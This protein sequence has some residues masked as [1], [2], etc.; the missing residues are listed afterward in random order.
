[1]TPLPW[2]TPTVCPV[3]RR[4]EGGD[5]TFDLAVVVDR[6][7]ALLESCLLDRAAEP[8]VD[9]SD[10][11]DLRPVRDALVSLCLLRLRA[12]LSAFTTRAGTPA[13]LKA[14]TSA[15]LSFCSQRVEVFVS[16]MSPQTRT[17][18]ACRRVAAAR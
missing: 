1:M 18:R 17:V 12:A 3:E 10:D 2:S 6:L 9:R 11:Q 5:A 7:D 4:V 8:R 13:A 15:G 16:G 14:F